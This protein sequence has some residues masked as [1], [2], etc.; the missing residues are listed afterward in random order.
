MNPVSSKFEFRDGRDAALDCE[1][2]AAVDDDMLDYLPHFHTGYIDDDVGWSY[3]FKRYEEL[4]VHANG[5]HPTGLPLILLLIHDPL[6]Y[7]R[8]VLKLIKV[9]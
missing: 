7:M 1:R 3:M 5:D 2:T 4:I 9:C 8:D 6:N